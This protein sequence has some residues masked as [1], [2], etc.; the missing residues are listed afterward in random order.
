M[1]KLILF[2]LLICPFAVF[3]QHTEVTIQDNQTIT[4]NKTITG[5]LLTHLINYTIG[6][7]LPIPATVQTN[8][9]AVITNGSS[10]NDCSTGGGVFLVLC[11]NTGS[12]WVSLGGGVFDGS[13][14]SGQVAVGSGPNTISGSSNLTFSGGNFTLSGD[15]IITGTVVGQGANDTFDFDTGGAGTVL[16]ITSVANAVGNLTT[17]THTLTSNS[18]GKLGMRVTVAGLTNGV[19]NGA[20]NVFNSDS[21]HITVYNSSG[22]A[23]THAGTGTIDTT[24]GN[25]QAAATLGSTTAANIQG[26]AYSLGNNYF[27]MY[28]YSPIMVTAKG[29]A[30]DAG[31]FRVLNDGAT[32]NHGLEVGGII[33]STGTSPVTVQLGHFNGMSL[34]LFNSP[35]STPSLYETATHT[36]SSASDVGVAGQ[37]AWDSSFI[38]ICIATNTWKRVG[39]ATW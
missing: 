7:T 15:A 10:I 31:Y 1:K 30:R 23:G 12:S 36:P 37:I 29:N 8:M 39:I 34:S 2:A 22:V 26:V 33:D 17:Y 18:I 21:T 3:A 25:T 27:E 9:V 20:F 5:N 24:I 14:S 32:G 38:Y 13:I 19:N 28:P 16:S 6:G 11:I 35:V 4:G